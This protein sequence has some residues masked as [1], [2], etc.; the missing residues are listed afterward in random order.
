MLED[1]S[2][3][4]PQEDVSEGHAWEKALHGQGHGGLTRQ[5][6]LAAADAA[7]NGCVDT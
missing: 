1:L 4:I 7:P 2:V 5:E 3:F 6:P